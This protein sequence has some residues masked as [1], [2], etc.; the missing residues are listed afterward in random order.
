[1]KRTL[2]SVLLC[3]VYLPVATAASCRAYTAAN[4]GSQAGY[5]TAK[6]AADSW[7]QREDQVSSSLEE[8]LGDISTMITMPRFPSLGGVLNKIEQEV[9]QA[10]QGEIDKY[11]PSTIDPWGDLNI[12]T[13]S[14][15]LPVTRQPLS[16]PV[17]TESPPA[18]VTAPDDNASAPFSLN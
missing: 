8:C 16:L 5:N 9:C 10:A 3:L 2:I 6:Q 1:M 15:T 18:T 11:V 12:P 4:T 13:T 7:A 14:M 17:E